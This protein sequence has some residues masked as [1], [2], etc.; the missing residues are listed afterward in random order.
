MIQLVYGE[1]AQGCT[2]FKPEIS[3]S[4]RLSR[5]NTYLWNALYREGDWQ[6]GEYDLMVTAWHYKSGVLPETLLVDNL[7]ESKK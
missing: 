4:Q 7:S 6:V 2:K 3:S 5:E 1:T